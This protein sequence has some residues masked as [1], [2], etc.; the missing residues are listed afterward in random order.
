MACTELPLAVKFCG[1]SGARPAERL[2]EDLR[3][4][5]EKTIRELLHGGLINKEGVR[6]HSLRL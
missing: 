3:R 6:S 2:K 1:A 4:D 5:F